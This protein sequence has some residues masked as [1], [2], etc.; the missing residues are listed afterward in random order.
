[1]KR[2]MARSGVSLPSVRADGKEGHH[3]VK[4]SHIQKRP[5]NMETDGESVSIFMHRNEAGVG[6][7]N[8][9]AIKIHSDYE[10][11]HKGSVCSLS[12]TS[13]LEIQEGYFALQ[14]YSGAAK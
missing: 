13:D 14:Q 10:N 2:Q 4:R 6:I 12:V 11:G 5:G 3:F 1:M 8:S 9:C 7:D